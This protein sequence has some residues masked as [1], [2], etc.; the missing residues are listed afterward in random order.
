LFALLS[1]GLAWL[2]SS[3]GCCGHVAVVVTLLLWSRG[4]CGHVA[5]VV[6]WLLW[7]R[8]CCGHVA[9]VVTWN[10]MAIMLRIKFMH[11][12]THN[13]TFVMVLLMV[14]TFST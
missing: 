12:N 8:G 3:R 9:A 6:T 13:R 4:C 11:T 5:A 10:I 1:Q 14:T 7:S 2:S